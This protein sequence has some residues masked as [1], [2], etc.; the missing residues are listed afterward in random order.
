LVCI[1]K[2]NP[3]EINPNKTFQITSQEF[4]NA[5]PDMGKE[6]AERDLISAIEKLWDRSIVIKHDKIYI[7]NCSVFFKLSTSFFFYNLFYIFYL[8]FYHRIFHLFSIGYR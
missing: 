4:F 2:L 3:L 5:F 1:G 8:L 6:N 7:K